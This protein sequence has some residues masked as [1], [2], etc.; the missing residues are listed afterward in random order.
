MSREISIASRTLIVLCGPAGAGKSTFAQQYFEPTQ[1]VSSD[2][3]R[4][5]ICDGDRTQNVDP[6]L[7]ELFHCLIPASLDAGTPQA[8]AEERLTLSQD[9]S[10]QNRLSVLQ[11]HLTR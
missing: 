4:A 1:V 8:H 7:F 11:P 3:C 2:H 6:D 10:F 9:A 5:L